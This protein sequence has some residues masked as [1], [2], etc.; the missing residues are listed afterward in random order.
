MK[1]LLT[2]KNGNHF[3]V[4]LKNQN[5]NDLSPLKI[6]LHLPKDNSAGPRVSRGAGCSQQE[7]EQLYM[8]REKYGYAKPQVKVEIKSVTASIIGQKNYNYGPHIKQAPAE[9]STSTTEN[10]SPTVENTSL[11]VE[12]SSSVLDKAGPGANESTP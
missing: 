5:L 3:I 8:K 12:N 7:L 2:K 6:D 4:N 9:N 11:T 10:S 1:K